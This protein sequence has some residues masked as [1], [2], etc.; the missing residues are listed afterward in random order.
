MAATI[1]GQPVLQHEASR[2]AG[3]AAVRPHQSLAVPESLTLREWPSTH[4]IGNRRGQVEQAP[5][6]CLS[7]DRTKDGHRLRTIVDA[8]LAKF[9]GVKR[10]QNP[11]LQPLSRH[12]GLTRR[13]A[14][15][16]GRSKYAD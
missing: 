2:H 14:R 3:R 7:I 10:N 15:A 1:V 11:T 4:L 12:P 6:S 13:Y 9:A 8:S 5:V 16:S